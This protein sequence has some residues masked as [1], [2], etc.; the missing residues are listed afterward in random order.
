VN[1]YLVLAIA[2]LVLIILGIAAGIVAVGLLTME[3]YKTM[4]A[5]YNNGMDTAVSLKEYWLFV[6]SV[7][8][9]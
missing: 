1:S 3:S 4:A 7:G 8:A 9:F 6:K 5:I 2:A